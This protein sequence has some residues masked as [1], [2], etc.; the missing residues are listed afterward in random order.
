MVVIELNIKG[1][2]AS[3]ARRQGHQCYLFD[4]CLEIDVD[5]FQFHLLR[6][7]LEQQEFDYQIAFLGF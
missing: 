6:I 3:Q 1:L 7:F 2:P 4:V 5:F